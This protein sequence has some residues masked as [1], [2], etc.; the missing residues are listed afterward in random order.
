M[1]RVLNIRGGH[2]SGKTEAVRQYLIQH[3]HEEMTLEI[4]RWTSAIN[5]IDG[6]KIIVLGYYPE[7]GCGGVDRYSSKQQT[8]ATIVESVRRFSPDS[9][10]YEGIMYSVTC[11]LSHEIAKLSRSLGYEWKAVLLE[12]E[13]AERKALLEYRND[14]ADYS[15]QNFVVSIQRARRSCEMLVEKGENIEVVDVTGWRKQDMG[16]IIEQRL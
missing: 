15:E 3:E 12:R 4:G 10:V 14:G 8:M 16:R 13:F 6:G 9:I 1:R 2:A 5:L 11:R 7:E